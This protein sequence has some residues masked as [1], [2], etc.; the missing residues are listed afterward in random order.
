MGRSLLRLKAGAVKTHCSPAVEYNGYAARSVADTVPRVA[1]SM[2]CRRMVMHCDASSGRGPRH[3]LTT[4][5]H[6]RA[7]SAR[8]F[9]RRPCAVSAEKG[10]GDW[11]GAAESVRVSGS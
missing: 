8:S 9:S 1:T 11:A 10:S 4:F 7:S 3:T 2:A 6:P 5:G